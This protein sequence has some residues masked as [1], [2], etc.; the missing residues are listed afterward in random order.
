MKVPVRWIILEIMPSN[1]NQLFRSIPCSRGVSGLEIL[2][3]TTIS[4]VLVRFSLTVSY[5]PVLNAVNLNER[6]DVQTQVLLV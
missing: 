4:Q 6:V 5:R 1:F 2:P 3:C